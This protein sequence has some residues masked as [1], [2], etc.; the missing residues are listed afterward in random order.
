MIRLIRVTIKKYQDYDHKVQYIYYILFYFI[1]KNC[2]V[3]IL[4]YHYL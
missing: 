3:I 2:I 4:Y 1:G